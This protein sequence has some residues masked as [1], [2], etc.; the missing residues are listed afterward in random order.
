MSDLLRFFA[1]RPF[2]PDDAGSYPIRVGDRAYRPL[3]L[4]D[5]GSLGVQ[6]VATCELVT[7]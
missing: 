1:E 7:G 3:D 5:V 6:W 4:I 2:P